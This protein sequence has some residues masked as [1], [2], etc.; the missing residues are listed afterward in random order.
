MTTTIDW[1]EPNYQVTEYIAEFWNT[2]SSVPIILLGMYGWIMHPNVKIRER[3]MFTMIAM[4]GIGSV[5]FHGLLHRYAQVL[6]ELPQ[7]F[8]NMLMIYNIWE[9]DR[10]IKHI[11]MSATF[12]FISVYYFSDNYDTFIIGTS[13]AVIATA[14]SAISKVVFISHPRKNCNLTALL[15]IA[16]CI[17]ITGAVCLYVDM[18]LCDHTGHVYLHALWHLLAALGTYMSALFTISV[19]NPRRYRMSSKLVLVKQNQYVNKRYSLV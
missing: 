8:G 3:C 14:T 1:C 13:F 2:L 5:L 19:V 12:I 10:C 18:K 6:D 4:V 7:F 11:I 9:T 16:L 17:Y 15:L